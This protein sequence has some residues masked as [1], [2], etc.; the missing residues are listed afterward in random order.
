MYIIL[1]D[2]SWHY[3]SDLTNYNLKKIYDVGNEYI[4]GMFK[5]YFDKQ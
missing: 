1:Y 3:F 5:M 2:K 4:F